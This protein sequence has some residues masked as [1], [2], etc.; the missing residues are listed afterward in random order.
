M[1]GNWSFGDYYKRE[2]ITW[3]WELLT[4]VWGAEYREDKEIL[5]VSIARLRQKLEDDAKKP[6]FLKTVY[7]VGYLFCGERDA[8]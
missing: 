5:W 3:A 4:G 8:L 6:F 7:G 2:A 1:L